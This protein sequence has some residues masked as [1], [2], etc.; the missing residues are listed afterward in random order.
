MELEDSKIIELFH[1]R[2]E[3]AI[4]ELSQKYGK[5]CRSIAKNI[6]NNELDSE[7]CVNDTWLGVWNTIPP[8]RPNPLISYVCR[9]VRNLSVKRYHN[10]TALKRN[11][12]YYVALHELSEC[13][14]SAVS[15]ESA[16]ESKDL[17]IAINGFLKGLNKENR[18]L[19]VRRY[20][21]SDSIE[22]LALLFDISCH[23]V[24]VRLSR[25]RKKLAE[26]LIKEGISI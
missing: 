17:A 10:N 12:Y 18:I 1:C 5:L 13:I 11:S 7:E 25:I 26:H 14:P 8:K 23:N 2:S 6:L 24:S 19:F 20:F 16:C 9:I 3:E 22:D 15:V 21:Y 4:D